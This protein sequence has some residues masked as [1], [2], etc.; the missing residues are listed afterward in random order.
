[1]TAQPVTDGGTQSGAHLDV[2]LTWQLKLGVAQSPIQTTTVT[3]A[4]AAA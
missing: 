2:T 3:I 4:G 1:V